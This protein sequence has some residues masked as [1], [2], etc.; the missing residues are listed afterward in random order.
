M[1]AKIQKKSATQAFA[2]IADLSKSN[3]SKKSRNPQA[4]A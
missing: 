2:R 3:G 1:A 4:T